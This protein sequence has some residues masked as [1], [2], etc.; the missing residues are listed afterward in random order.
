M[1]VARRNRIVAFECVA[2]PVG[3][4]AAKLLI[5]QYLGEQVKQHARVPDVAARN[6]N[7]PHIQ[8]FPINSDTYFAA[9]AETETTMLTRVLLAFTFSLDACAVDQQV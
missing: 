8:C 9:K 6:L 3:G 1:S 7:G 5:G 4:H 2:G